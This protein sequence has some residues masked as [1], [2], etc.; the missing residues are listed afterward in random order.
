MA[1]NL[2]RRRSISGARAIFTINDV[3][4]G[5]ALGVD[6][7]EMVLYEPAVVLGRMKVVEHIPVGYEVTTF[8]AQRLR[9]IDDDLRGGD[10]SFPQI[11]ARHGNN[12]TEMLEQLLLMDEIKACIVDTITNRTFALLEGVRVASRG[13]S[14]VPRRLT[15]ENI[16]FVATSM[17]DEA[18]ANGA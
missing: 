11:M 12:D 18:E 9:L 2:R 6:A 10:G 1:D 13:L 15:V 16:A 3:E 5:Y 4:L 17:L 7:E 14:V 8:T